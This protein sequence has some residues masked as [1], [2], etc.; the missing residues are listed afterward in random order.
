[1]LTRQV[2]APRFTA[3]LERTRGAAPPETAPG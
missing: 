3:F 2:G 1:M